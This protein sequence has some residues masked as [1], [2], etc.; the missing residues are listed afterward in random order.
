M[1]LEEGQIK[2]SQLQ[3]QANQAGA[4]TLLTNALI[5]WNTHYIF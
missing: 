1:D 4:L 5:V 2:K 3:N